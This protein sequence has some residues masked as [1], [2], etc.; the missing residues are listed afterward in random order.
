M[1][2]DK[3]KVIKYGAAGIIIAALV[4]L[5]LP[6]QEQITI[7]PY[8]SLEQVPG[9]GLQ[10]VKISEE[11]ADLRDLIITIEQVETQQPNSEWAKISNGETSWNI[12]QEI[13]KTFAMDTSDLSPGTYSKIRLVIAQG[14][15]YNKATLSNDM[16]I[17]VNAPIYL[18]IDV[19]EFTVETGL[20]ELTLSLSLG[21]GI[22]SNHMLPQYHISIGSTRLQ[23][24]VSHS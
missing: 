13:H 17:T 11:Q 4:L 1:A 9:Y 23:A 14:L 24:E 15:E 6:V 12:I 10:Y 2:Y 19:P 7:S 5:F 22:A 18:E 20:T 16:T 21:Q 3:N 8:V